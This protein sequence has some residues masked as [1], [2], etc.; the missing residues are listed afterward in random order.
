MAAAAR[1]MP[2]KKLFTIVLPAL[3]KCPFVGYIIYIKREWYF[4]GEKP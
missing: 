4:S 3:D 2:S 1:F